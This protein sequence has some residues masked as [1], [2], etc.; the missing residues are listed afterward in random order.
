MNRKILN[1]KY[2]VKR[3]LLFMVLEKEVGFFSSELEIKLTL[4]KY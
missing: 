2:K 4:Y 1:K 3:T